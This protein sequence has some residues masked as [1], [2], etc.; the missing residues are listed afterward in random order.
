VATRRGVLVQHEEQKLAMVK[1]KELWEEEKG[2]SDI[3]L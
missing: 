3:M 2:G 1:C